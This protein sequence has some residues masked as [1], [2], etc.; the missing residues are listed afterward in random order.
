VIEGY[1]ADI[2]NVFILRTLLTGPINAGIAQS[3]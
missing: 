2:E 1:G 3:V